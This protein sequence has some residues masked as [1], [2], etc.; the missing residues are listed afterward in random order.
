M[1]T[2]DDFDLRSDELALRLSAWMTATSPTREPAGL[3]A[4]VV[5]RTGSVRQRPAFLVRTGVV[6][7][8]VGG[9]SQGSVR[10]LAVL[11]LVMLL[12]L[13]VA[14][15]IVVALGRPTAIL[16]PELEAA[17]LRTV[18]RLS[19]PVDENGDAIEVRAGLLGDDTILVVGWS[20]SV[21][22]LT[23]G[24]VRSVSTGFR[25]G[26]PDDV[27]R[28]DDGRM[29]ITSYAYDSSRG[30]Y[31]VQLYDP[32]AES[33]S[34]ADDLTERRISPDVV[35]LADGRVLLAGGTRADGPVATAEIFDPT[36]GAFTP[37]GSMHEA[38]SN[39]LLTLLEDGRVLVFN[40]M[41]DCDPDCRAT[42]AEVYDPATGRFEAT[43]E[44]VGR[45]SVLIGGTD[46]WRTSPVRLADGRVL[47][48]GGQ[49]E[50][51]GCTRTRGIKA[52]AAELYDPSTGTF[53]AAL[54]VPHDVS[55]ATLLPD[56]R[57]LVAG[58]WTAFLPTVISVPDPAAAY[59]IDGCL[60]P[61]STLTDPWI[62]IYDPTTGVV[63][64]SRNPI[65]GE[66]SLAVDTDHAYS[67]SLALDDGRVLLFGRPTNTAVKPIVV[68]QGSSETGEP[69]AGP[70][71]VVDVFEASSAP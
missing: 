48:F 21:V 20:A 52:I 41:D 23:T 60:G 69:G 9:W 18:A 6:D 67:S 46:W 63:H 44:M 24:Q 57:V 61:R 22:D 55:E 65:T 17:S 70:G 38:R 25:P 14:G 49:I 3:V 19:D 13:T 8:G 28:L 36:T 64:Q 26:A 45:A 7:G 39:P 54:P 33:F 62:G 16:E 66:S 4:G 10:R 58:Q 42:S 5:D 31:V 71:L 43:G 59:L 68:D 47:V 37:T 12:L 40:G 30:R 2:T 34:L 56:G 35:K 15:A 32:A 11:G 51:R 1:K 50:P 27:V 29:L 53:T